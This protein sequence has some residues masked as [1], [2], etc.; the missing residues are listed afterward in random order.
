MLTC[1]RDLTY[2]EGSTISGPDLLALAQGCP[3]LRSF[4]LPAASELIIGEPCPHG[5]TI[6]DETID[7]FARALPKLEVFTFGLEN[8]STLTYKAVVSLARYCPELNYFHIA[9][10]IFIPDLIQ[11]LEEAGK[12]LG[13]APLPSVSFM[14][15][16]LDEDIQHKYGDFRSLA[17]RLVP[18][19][20][21]LCEFSITDGSEDD[22]E[23]QLQVDSVACYQ[24]MSL[25]QA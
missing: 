8:R 14:T 22:D 1:T 24:G 18:L 13:A 5:K 9:A 16:Y 15:F 21:G 25:S 7:E 23:F 4:K 6:D 2:S 3:E 12:E 20:P 10:D 17:S 19:T 11:G